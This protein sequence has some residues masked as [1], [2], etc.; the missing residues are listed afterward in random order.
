[1]KYLH[2]IVEWF[3]KLLKNILGGSKNVTVTSRDNSTSFYAENV[4]RDL[5]VGQENRNKRQG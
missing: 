3:Q 4:G 2:K 1:M 5:N